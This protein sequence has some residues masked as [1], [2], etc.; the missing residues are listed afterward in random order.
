MLKSDLNPITQICFENMLFKLNEGFCDHD[1]T[2][3]IEN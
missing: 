2:L 3:N 1:F